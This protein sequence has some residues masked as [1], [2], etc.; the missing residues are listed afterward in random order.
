M[1]LKFFITHSW[2]DNAFAR[3]LCDDLHAHGLDGFF[4]VYSV[5]PGDIISAEISR[6]LESCD[7]YVPILSLAALES[8]WCE[9]EINAAIT[10]SKL[11]GRKGRPRIIPVLVENCQD[12]MPIFLRS[13]LYIN[14]ADRYEDALRELLSRGFEVTDESV[15]VTQPKS[16]SVSKTENSKAEAISAQR[17]KNRPIL[18]AVVIVLLVCL[19]VGGSGILYSLGSNSSLRPPTSVSS[20][21]ATPPAA[22]GMPAT[23]TRPQAA[24]SRGLIAFT[25]SSNGNDE[26]YVMNADGSGQTN[27]TN[28]PAASDLIPAWSSDGK[29]ILFS[30][31]RDGNYEIYLMNPDGS[32]QT[33][34]TNNPADDLAPQES[35]DGKKI[36]FHSNR[37]GN[38]QIY[39]MNVD[40]S[41]Q[42]RLTNNSTEDYYPQWLPD[43][44]IA[45]SHGNDGTYMMNADG[46]GQTRWT[47]YP[48]GLYP[49][50][51]PNRRQIAVYVNH[52]PNGE[53]YVMNADGSDATSLSNPRGWIDYGPT[54]SP[55]GKRIAFTSNRDGDDEIYVMNADG[56]GQTRLTYDP[57]SDRNAAWQP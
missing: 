25:R 19:I 51:S 16:V 26:I 36:A 31:N 2:H 48:G 41:G 39:V 54:W 5:R 38:H 17:W 50:W 46:S 35:P 29:K 23:P 8:P 20:T 27:L 53:I 52:Y 55:D 13:R 1:Q 28:N 4:D 43:G 56:S 45:F 49:V 18:V 15:A 32:G 14:F 40:G 12:D 22:A 11:P 37:N 6:G 9:E 3:R 10:L 57:G 30:S 7:I 24:N 42:T 47:T 21:S 44:R 33:R 34:L